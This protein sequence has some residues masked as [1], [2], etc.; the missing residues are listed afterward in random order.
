MLTLCRVLKKK[1]RKT[2]ELLLFTHYTK[3]Y[4]EVFNLIF[5]LRT[6]IASSLL[7]SFFKQA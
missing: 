6:S 3:V 1:K 4:V 5:H 2:Y 7:T